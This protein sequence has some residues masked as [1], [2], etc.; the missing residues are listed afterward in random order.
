MLFRFTHLLPLAL[1]LVGCGGTQT[2]GPYDQNAADGLGA[3]RTFDELAKRQLAAEEKGGGEADGGVM[4]QSVNRGSDLT[5]G[6]DVESLSEIQGDDKAAVSILITHA[7]LA[8][9]IAKSK[10]RSTWHDG[11]RTVGELAGTWT[12]ADGSGHALVFGADGSFGQEFA[13]DMT[14]GVY[15]ISD[16]GRILTYSHRRGVGLRSH[17]RFDGKVI[18][19]PRGPVPSAEWKR[20]SGLGTPAKES[21][22]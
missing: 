6:S 12:A 10:D 5:S 22:K 11:E 18:R 8:Q 3:N 20:I 7:D 17:F 14:E 21:G 15:S 19:G 4:E 9:A 2:S 16:K 1:C 13:G